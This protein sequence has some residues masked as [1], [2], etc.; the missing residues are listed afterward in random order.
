[1]LSKEPFIDQSISQSINQSVCQSVN[2]PFSFSIC[3]HNSS[4]KYLLP[5]VFPRIAIS[6]SRKC[7][8]YLN[9]FYLGVFYRLSMGVGLEVGVSPLKHMMV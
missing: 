1:M 9:A 6:C 8:K 3:L 7:M 2:Q 5:V 4:D